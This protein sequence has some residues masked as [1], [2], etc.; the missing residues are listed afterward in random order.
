MLWGI[1]V[2]VPSKLRDLSTRGA[3]LWTSRSGENEGL[4]RKPC[5]VAR[6]KQG[7]G[8][9][10]QG[11]SLLTSSQGQLCMGMAYCSLAAY[12]HRFHWSCHG[13][14]VARCSA[15]PLEV[16]GG[17]D[18]EHYYCQETITA[19]RELF[20]GHGLPEQVVSDN[21]PQFTSSQFSH[22]LAA[23]GV[24]H[25]C[26][27]PYQPAAI[28]AVERLVQTVKK[29][30]KSGQRYGVELDQISASFMLQS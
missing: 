26:C 12:S 3:S 24:K 29:A 20:A 13:K 4:G 11:L 6:T 17:P 7:N 27:A 14:E 23:N 5:V 15:H 22:F 21:A 28:E 30:I 18:D 2:N 19:L 1:R 25:L 10:N 9:T 16:A 8:D